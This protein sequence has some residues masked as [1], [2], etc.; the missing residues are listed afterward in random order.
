MLLAPAFLNQLH[1]GHWRYPSIMLVYGEEPLYVRRVTD[2]L[3]QYF[4][5]QGFLQRDRYDVDAQ[6]DWQGL[7]METQT[8][9]LFADQRLI[10]LAMPS[11][12]PGTPGS[13]F[14]LNWCKQ[15]PQDCVLV[16]YCERLESRQVKAKWAQAIESAGLVVQAKPLAQQ[17]LV[18]W[19]QQEAISHQLQLTPDAAA[20]LAERVEGNMLAAEQEL[21]KLSLR[22]PASAGEGRVKQLTDADIAEQVVDQAHYQLF[23]L[24]SL[25]LKGEAKQALHVLHRLQQ[26]GTEAPIVLW[27]FTKELR[28]LI[29]L[30]QASNVHL[31]MKEQ[32]IWA[33]KQAEYRQALSRHP[34]KVWHRLLLDAYQIDRQVKGLQLGDPWLGLSDLAM[35]I[36]R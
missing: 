7:A 24:S 12:N 18:R 10:E 34:L 25:L 31:A 15:P 33:S 17:E 6:F 16:I 23:A 35:K 4:K 8:G 9:S 21:I 14:V 22:Y 36:A 27:L 20:L 28:T 2:A 26:E 30:A 11:G 1:Q 32:R 13:Q 19:C 29:E 5:A 3:R